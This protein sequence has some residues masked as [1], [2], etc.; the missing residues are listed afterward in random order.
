MAG[1]A[2]NSVFSRAY[3]SLTMT[4]HVFYAILFEYTPSYK[5]CQH[6]FHCPLTGINSSLDSLHSISNTW[7]S[8]VTY[9]AFRPYHDYRNFWDDNMWCSAGSCSHPWTRTR[10]YCTYGNAV[11]TFNL[12]S[13]FIVDGLNYYQK[14]STM[15]LLCSYFIAKHFCCYWGGIR[16]RLTAVTVYIKTI[17]FSL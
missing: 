11:L 4:H 15:Y 16:V 6:C 14:I 1:K 2:N 13:H 7:P 10:N 17:Q 12:W 3:M 8:H 9:A 5:K